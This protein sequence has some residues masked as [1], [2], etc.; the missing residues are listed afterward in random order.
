VSDEEFAKL[1]N[2][3]AIMSAW[4]AIFLMLVFIGLLT[5]G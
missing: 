2:V 1:L 4:A 5:I 3:F